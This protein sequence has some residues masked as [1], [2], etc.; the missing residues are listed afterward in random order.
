M[1]LGV[2]VTSVWTL[3][4]HDRSSAV[5]VFTSFL[6]LIIS[7]T[8]WSGVVGLWVCIAISQRLVG[9]L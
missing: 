1:G 4:K 6:Q 7:D 8:V 9:I 5:A 2:C 3:L